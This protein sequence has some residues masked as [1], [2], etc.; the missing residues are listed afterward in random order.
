MFKKQFSFFHFH[1]LHVSRNMT[2]LFYNERAMN[3]Y[4][5][6]CLAIAIATQNQAYNFIGLIWHTLID[7]TRPE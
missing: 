2:P 5:H 3:L 7:K 1:K 6:V 4:S